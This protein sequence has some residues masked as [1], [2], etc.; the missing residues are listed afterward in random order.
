M[1]I[2]GVKYNTYFAPCWDCKHRSK[3]FD[4][5]CDAYPKGIPMP[6]LEGKNKHQNP[7]KNDNGIQFEPIKRIK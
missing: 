5:T 6:I 2:D 4:N 3:P 7:Y 1:K